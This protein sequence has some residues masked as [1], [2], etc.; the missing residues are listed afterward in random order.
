M[1]LL[2]LLSH[3][4]IIFIIF[5]SLSFYS[6]FFNGMEATA[7]RLNQFLWWRCGGREFV[8]GFLAWVYSWVSGVWVGFGWRLCGVWVGVWVVGFRSDGC[9]FFRWV[10]WW[11]SVKMMMMRKS[12]WEQMGLGW[13]ETATGDDRS[14]GWRRWRLED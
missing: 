14:R 3:Y 1:V 12:W 6:L 4:F 13:I 8:H 9:D 2:S 7:W 11:V 10:W 5:L